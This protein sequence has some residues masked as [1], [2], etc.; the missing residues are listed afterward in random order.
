MKKFLSLFIAL[1]LI[2]SLFATTAVAFAEEAGE[3]SQGG[4]VTAPTNPDGGENE[5]DGEETETPRE[6]V[7]INEA[8]L[9]E[10]LEQDDW[11]NSLKVEMGDH[12]FGVKLMEAASNVQAVFANIKYVKEDTE[13]EKKADNDKI[14]VEYC[15]PSESPKGQETW[16]NST[17]IT[18][19]IRLSSNGW[20]L[21]RIVV[22][23]KNNEVLA[24]S[25][26]YF[27]FYAEDTKRPVVSLSTTMKN[28]VESGLTAETKYSIPTSGLTNGSSDEMSSTT[29]T[30]E[31]YKVVDGKDV[32]IYDSKSK[33]VTENYEKFVDK[34][35]AITPSK[36]DISDKTVYKVVYSVVDSY[37][38]K[39]VESDSDVLNYGAVE[40]N[41]VMEL[42]VVAA[43][44]DSNKSA[45]NVWEIVLFCIAGLCAIGI[46]VLLCIKPKEAAPANNARP[47][48]KDSDGEAEV[49]DDTE[50]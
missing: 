50:E 24:R 1:L 28:K 30:F 49:N 7:E 34:D 18:E 31:V 8:L 6:K 9:K 33:E 40:F 25:T 4:E 35:G 10:Y 38:Y 12:K 44:D 42:K 19:N 46:V 20:Y 11:F 45:V 32:L 16:Q 47:A 39:G 41:P 48:V 23:D 27:S 37:G 15:R 3:P 22:K 17:L 5:G 29:V 21:F 43:P 13:T 2:V 36:D 26:S 14:Y